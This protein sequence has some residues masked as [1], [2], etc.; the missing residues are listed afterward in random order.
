MMEDKTELVNHNDANEDASASWVSSNSFC[1]TPLLRPTHIQTILASSGFRSWGA[2]P[3]GDAAE[4]MILETSGSVRLL[5]FYSRQNG[6]EA[7][8]L[9]ILLHGWEGSVDSTYMLCTGRSLFTAGYSVFRL[10][11][12][13]HGNSH[14]LNTG[15]FYAVLL[16]EVFEAVNRIARLAGELPVFLVGFSLGGNFV[17]RILQ[18]CTATPIEN[19]QH[20]VAISPVLDPEKATRQTDQTS[21]IRRYFLKKWCRSLMKKQQLFP[22]LYDFS[23]VLSLKTIRAVTDVMLRAYSNFS[24]AEDYFR[25]YAVVKGALKNITVPTTIITAADDPII[26][27]DDFYQLETNHFTRL[28][29]QKH[30]GHNGFIDGF[31]LRSWYERQIT[32]IFDDSV[33][34]KM[35]ASSAYRP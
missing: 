3:M 24:S 12:R 35:L 31:Y 26:P 32:L 16:D 22:D 34:N 28:A 6:V 8:G 19:L 33:T 4:E 1:P 5:G 29:I 23:R 2:N 25:E 13:D 30:G 18:R 10:N 14:H 15:I 17:L 27:V 11:F 21:L 7:K 9:V 20:A